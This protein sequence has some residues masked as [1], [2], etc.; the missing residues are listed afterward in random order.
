[1]TGITK[2]DAALLFFKRDIETIMV[3]TKT[4]ALFYPNNHKI[5]VN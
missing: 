3:F 2:E 5:K 4:K 1:M